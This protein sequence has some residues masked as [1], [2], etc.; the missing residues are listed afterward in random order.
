MPEVIV[1]GARYVPDDTGRPRIGVGITT[2]N[3]P[4]TFRQS[5]EQIV[6][7][8]P[9]ARIVVV[10]DASDV[11]V[12]VATFRFDTVAGIAAAKNKCIELLD[13]C[14][15]LFLWDDDAW[16]LVDEWWVPYVDSP[17]PHLMYLFKDAAGQPAVLYEDDTHIAFSESRGVMMY[18]HRSCIDRI[19]GMN[20]AFG[21]WG[22]EHPD[23]SNRIFAAGLTTWRFADVAGSGMLIHSLDEQ[24][25]AT[26]S[27]EQK[28]RN[29]LVVRN[30]A[31]HDEY[32]D[33][34]AFMPWRPQT[35]VV[36]TAYLTGQPDPQTGR[37]WPADTRALNPL[38]KSLDGR[39][40]VVLTDSL[41]GA[42]TARVTYATVGA[43]L[44]PYF[45]RWVAAYQW[46]RA[47]PEIGRVWCVDATDVE[48]LNDP[49]AAMQPGRLYVGSEA[50]IIGCAWLREHHRA[51]FLSTFI[52]AHADR[53]LLNAGLI[54]GSRDL[55]MAFA[56]DMAGIYFDHATRMHVGEDTETLGL[57]D[58]AAF[59]Y[60]AWTRY[61]DV[62]NYG[63]Q[64]NT[65]F[66]ANQRTDWAWWKH[67]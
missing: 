37:A 48:M 41:T 40:L 55:V 13:G 17:E 8:T 14:E 27:V 53:Q 18:V 25:T 11:P 65:V 7:H 64:V 9:G 1:D 33:R 24:G 22:W 4:D 16:P 62:I 28:V 46:L 34:P 21:R 45:Q 58:M 38:I 6:K 43:H 63:P 29:D 2:H 15:H 50:S 35:D 61:A 67:K 42:D 44:S 31:I 23:L 5:Y 36:L 20:P 26:R 19:G 30:K 3:R 60:L 10:D 51:A 57:G 56:H 59:N 52:D 39:R 66:K 32:R 54:G 49:F 47:H 12:D